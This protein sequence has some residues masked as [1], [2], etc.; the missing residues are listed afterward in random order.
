M[1]RNLL[2][3]L[4]CITAICVNAQ[5]STMAKD[6]R[7]REIRDSIV[8]ARTLAALEAKLDSDKLHPEKV[9]V[10]AGITNTLYFIGGEND[11]VAYTPLHPMPSG[12]TDNML[13][14][15]KSKVGSYTNDVKWL[16]YM[17]NNGLKY[18]TK[19]VVTASTDPSKNYE[20]HFE[21]RKLN[22]GDYHKGRVI[23]LDYSKKPWLVKVDYSNDK[24][25][26]FILSP[27]VPKEKE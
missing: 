17:G 20:V 25:V 2:I 15:F 19:V 8:T 14:S 21:S 24:G 13:W 10:T 23:L 27:Y 1:K 4:S 9:T 3:L 22:E 12:P 6:A 26:Y 5:N 11:S 18:T 7:E 16:F